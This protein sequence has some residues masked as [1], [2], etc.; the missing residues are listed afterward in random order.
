MYSQ[1][2]AVKMRSFK[3]F[4]L[5]L[6]LRRFSDGINRGIDFSNKYDYLNIC[7]NKYT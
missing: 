7:E 2:N 4:S 3:S 5:R 1:G 6:R